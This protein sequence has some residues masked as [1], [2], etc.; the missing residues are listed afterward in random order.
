MREY[1]SGGI[2][3]TV[4]DGCF[5]LS[6][7]SMVLADFC[8]LPRGAAVCDLGSGCGALGLL[9]LRDH[10]DVRVTGLEILPDAAAQ[11]SSMVQQTSL[12]AMALASSGEIAPDAA[13]K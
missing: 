3:M 4:T 8:R 11:R 5:R 10:P 9:L 1:F 2:T 12:R 13:G 7:D 6:T